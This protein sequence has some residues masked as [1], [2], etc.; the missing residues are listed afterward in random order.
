VTPT[1]LIQ[2]ATDGIGLAA[3]GALALDLDDLASAALVAA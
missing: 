3:V 2:G 1:T